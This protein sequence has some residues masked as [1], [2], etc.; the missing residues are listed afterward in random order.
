MT[1]YMVVVERGANQLGSA[2]AGPPLVYS[3]RRN[4]DGGAAADPRGHRTSHCGMKEDGLPVR[5]VP[6]DLPE[7]AAYTREPGVMSA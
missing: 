6:D 3:G 4:A 5:N 1:R 7:L 2:C